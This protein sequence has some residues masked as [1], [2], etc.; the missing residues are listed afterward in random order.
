MAEFNYTE[1][2]KNNPLLTVVEEKLL[3]ESLEVNE[4]EEATETQSS[5]T[6]VSALKNEIREMIKSSLEDGIE[7]DNVQ[8][9]FGTKILQG[10]A[11]ALTAV[12]IGRTQLDSLGDILNVLPDDVA[13]QVS[14][15]IQT[16]VDSGVLGEAEGE[17]KP[18]GRS[19]YF[20]AGSK[21]R[22]KQR[23]E[24]AV[25]D[26][27]KHKEK[28]GLK[29]DED[30]IE[31]EIEADMEPEMEPAAPEVS[32]GFTPEEEAIQNN[33]KTALDNAIAIGDDKLAD[34]IGNSITFFT[35][36]HV[37]ER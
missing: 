11:A 16:A 1:Y 19:I 8:E 33:L 24:K 36:T 5:K 28:Y 26:L 31:A 34:Q 6:T 18:D 29:E 9:G 2:I 25:D 22:I 10:L 12:G 20:G 15:I 30:E 14:D 23:R 32:V 13:Q 27:Q 3:T 21:D 7:E 37:V 17:E 4:T 35:R